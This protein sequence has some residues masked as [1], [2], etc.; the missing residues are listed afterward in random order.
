MKALTP[1]K[2]A[3]ITGGTY[4]GSDSERDIIVQGAVRDNRDVKQ[5]NLFVCIQGERTDGHLYANKAFEAGATCCLA[6]KEINNAKGPYIIVES[7]LESIKVLGEYYRSLFKIPIIGIT[8]SV[9]KTTAKELIATVLGAKYNVLK[10]DKNLNNELGVPLT[11]L[12]LT[13]QH[14]AAVIEM[15]ISDFG[16]MGRLAKMVRPDIFVMTIIGYSHIKELGDLNGVL[17]AKTEAFAYMP[18][19]SVAIMNGDDELLANFNTGRKTITFGLGRYNDVYAKNINTQET[20]SITMDVI[21]KN[22]VF[23][24][25]IPAYGS[26]IPSLALATVAVGKELGLDDNEIKR[27]LLSYSPVGSRSNVLTIN[28]ITIIDDCYNANPNSVIAALC[29]LTELKGR[30][31]AILGDMLNLGKNAETQHYEIGEYAAK[32]GIDILLCQGELAQFIF[33]GFISKSKKTAKYY[34][35]MP[36]LINDIPI[37]IR[38]GDTVLVKA[39]RGMYFERLLPALEKSKLKN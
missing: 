16:E 28:D 18:S 17:K 7:T 12:S 3:E 1:I 14:D 29:S 31:V 36:E 19:N 30:R 5:G 11:L 9:G 8:G 21:L 10:T 39:S 26:H 38:K 37:K 20:K 4:V 35:E 13:E 27:G 15:G 24:A 6:E 23:S 34:A 25:K 2:I 22:D 32:C 33:E